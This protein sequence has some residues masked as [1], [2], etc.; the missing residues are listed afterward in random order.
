ME[1]ERSVDRSK[2][3][4]RSPLTAA[5]QEE[6]RNHL[7]E[8]LSNTNRLLLDDGLRKRYHMLS[9]SDLEDESMETKD[10]SILSTIQRASRRKAAASKTYRVLNSNLLGS[11]VDSYSY[12]N[13][14][15]KVK[16]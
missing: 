1:T 16:A 4:S 9:D 2:E 6:F 3:S 5:R 11:K 13:L 15:M 7:K 14:P 10:Q 8:I 12:R